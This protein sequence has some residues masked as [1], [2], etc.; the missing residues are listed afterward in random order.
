MAKIYNY[1]LRGSSDHL[2]RQCRVLKK[3]STGRLDLRRPTTG[4]KMVQSLQT[5]TP[6]KSSSVRENPIDFLLSSDSEGE[7]SVRAVKVEDEGSKSRWAE[8]E[9]QGV[10]TWGIVDTGSDITIVGGELF[11]VVATAA[12]LRKRDFKKPDKTPHTYAIFL[13]WKDGSHYI[14]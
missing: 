9:L 5:K 1:S 12:R 8:V 10:P 2:L 6:E 3:E 14:F 11:K 13:G 7:E 4:T